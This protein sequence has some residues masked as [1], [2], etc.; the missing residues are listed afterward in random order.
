M[1][2]CQRSRVIAVCNETSPVRGF[3]LNGVD[4]M[5]VA[6]NLLALKLSRRDSSPTTLICT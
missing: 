4:V 5:G 1:L 6:S 3:A 2:R